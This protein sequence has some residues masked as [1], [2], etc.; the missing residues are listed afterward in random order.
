[1]RHLRPLGLVFLLLSS[2]AASS[3]EV[4]W[5]LVLAGGRVLDPETNLDAV[6]W[7]GIH[8]GRIGEISETPLVG[9]EV[10]D[11]SGLVVAP[12]FIDLH[13]HGQEPRSYDYLAR[14]GV[15][16]ALELEAG[17]HHLDG[18]LARREGR[19][20]IHFG[21]SA[22]HIPARAYVFDGVGLEHFL[23]AR[24]MERGLRLLWTGFRMWAFPAP[25]Y[26]HVVADREHRDRIVAALA[27]ELDQGAIG[28]G[29]GLAYT[30]GADGPEITAVFEL[31]AER[32][33]PCFVHLPAQDGPLDMAPLE[34]VLGFARQTGAALHV[35]H[36]NSSSQDAVAAYLKRIEEVRSEGMDVTVEAY[37]YTAGSTAIESALFDEGWREKRETDYGDLQWAATGERLTEESFARYRKTGG[38]VIIHFMKPEMVATAISHPLTMIASDGMP[39][40]D[41]S[42]HPRGAGTRARVLAE[43]VRERGTLDLMSAMRKMSL[44]P[45]R[46]LE[47]F[48]PAMRN[49]GRIRVG[50]DADL[51]VFDPATVRDRATFED[52]HQPSEGI[53]HVLVGGTFVVRDDALVEGVAPG[54]AL[55]ASH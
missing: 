52:P 48:V 55:R 22:G 51:V 35:V 45:A 30:P 49:K 47:A 25:K 40:L 16:S 31:A 23:T 10:I 28:I 17:V 33:V 24:A 20:R 4:G 44:D 11:V 42:P 14:D 5:E 34:T 41:V 19:A 8:E 6:R 54:Q 2:P 29:M 27:E 15:T 21:A 46:R 39:M 1:M 13:I 12:G 9:I 18:F 32:G 36:V 38:T 53:P 50:A 43:Y 26:G 3:A 7:I 37:P